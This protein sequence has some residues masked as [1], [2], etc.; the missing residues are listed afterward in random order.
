M[1]QATH[2]GSSRV[3]DALAKTWDAEDTSSWTASTH[4]P[5]SPKSVDTHH[6][7]S[8][9]EAD[10]GHF[11]AQWP[12]LNSAGSAT[13]GWILRDSADDSSFATIGTGLPV[14]FDA[15]TPWNPKGFTIP[16]PRTKRR[17]LQ[18]QIIVG[19]AALTGGALTMSYVRGPGG[20]G[21]PVG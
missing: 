4:T 9:D 1:T 6:A 16:V 20:R 13:V 3:A 8:R 14:A 15:T 11:V 12:G 17:Y 21:A 5:T 18:V 7:N 2:E 19:T 10:P